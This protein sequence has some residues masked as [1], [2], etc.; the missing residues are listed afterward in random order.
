MPWEIKGFSALIWAFGID[1]VLRYPHALFYV[2]DRLEYIK[3]NDKSLYVIFKAFP[4]HAPTSFIG[5]HAYS[6]TKTRLI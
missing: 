1:S 5:I 2:F 6:F 3:Y 4:P